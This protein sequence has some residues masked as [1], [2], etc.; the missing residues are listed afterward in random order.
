MAPYNVTREV[1][2]EWLGDDFNICGGVVRHAA[3]T[4][5]AG[6]IAGHLQ[7]GTAEAIETLGRPLESL[8]TATV[9][10]GALN[11]AVSA[12]GFAYVCRRLNAIEKQLGEISGKLDALLEASDRLAWRQALESRS[13][14]AAQIENVLVSLRTSD[15]TG[16]SH[17][18]A[19]LNESEKLYMALGDHLLMD[20]RRVYGDPDVVQPVLQMA[21]AAALARSRALAHLGH[22]AESLQVIDSLSTWQQGAAKRLESPLVEMPIWLASLDATQRASCRALVQRERSLPEV[23]TRAVPCS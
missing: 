6:E 23:L 15:L 8:L 7:F 14:W 17:A 22:P 20:S 2:S 13:K 10:L 18:A 19:M 16:A 1:P 11:L 12:I 4:P 3:G 5:H 21:E 9:A